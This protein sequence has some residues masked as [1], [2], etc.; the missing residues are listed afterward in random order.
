M[1]RSPFVGNDLDLEPGGAAGAIV[2]TNHLEAADT[3]PTLALAYRRFQCCHRVHSA[4]SG[5]TL[6]VRVQGTTLFLAGQEYQQSLV[7]RTT[8]K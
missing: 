8:Q 5:T 1:T 4:E 3:S 2:T 7:T 6:D